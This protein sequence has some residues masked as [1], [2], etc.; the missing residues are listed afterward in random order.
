[1]LIPEQSFLERISPYM[2]KEIHVGLWYLILDGS[3][4]HASEAAFLLNRIT[5]IQQRSNSLL[6][7]TR[8]NVSPE[9]ALRK[10]Q[11]EAG[12]LCCSMPTACPFWS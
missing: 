5:A 1:L 6:P 7:N 3:Q 4:V 2:K 11:R 8:L 12:V 9:E 10:Y